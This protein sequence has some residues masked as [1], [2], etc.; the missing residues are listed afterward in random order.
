MGIDHWKNKK[1]LF[2]NSS[3]VIYITLNQ[4]EWR[5]KKTLLYYNT[6][7]YIEQKIYINIS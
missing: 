5:Y 6:I 7:F 4:Q 1:D 3:G 2:G